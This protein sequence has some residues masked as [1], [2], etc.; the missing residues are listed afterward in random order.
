M[1]DVISSFTYCLLADLLISINSIRSHLR[2]SVS[3]QFILCSSDPKRGLWRTGYRTYRT[4]HAT[5]Q[6]Q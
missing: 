5:K 2:F 6:K 1:S 3:I 4:T